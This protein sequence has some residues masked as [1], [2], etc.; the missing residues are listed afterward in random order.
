[1]SAAALHNPYIRQLSRPW[2]PRQKKVKH[3]QHDETNSPPVASC[4]LG[5]GVN[6]GYRR[7]KE[8]SDCL[9]KV[10]EIDTGLLAKQIKGF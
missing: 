1:M 7:C 6:L 10:Y 8:G 5:F 4:G 9:Q 3:I 2:P